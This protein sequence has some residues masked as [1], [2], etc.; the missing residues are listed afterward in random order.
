M[1]DQERQAS[2]RNQQEL[3]SECVMISVVGGF[4]LHVYHVQGGIRTAN[5]DH[6]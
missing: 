6:L 4:E 5:V 2:H 3:H 1:V